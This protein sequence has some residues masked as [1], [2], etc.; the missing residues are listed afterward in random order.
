MN[1][2]RLLFYSQ[3]AVGSEGTSDSSPAVQGVL[4][5][6]KVVGRAVLCPPLIAN[7]RI[8]T[9]ENGV[10][11]FDR[12]LLNLSPRR[13]RSDAPCLHGLKFIWAIRPET[14]GYFQ[15]VP[16]GLKRSE[17]RILSK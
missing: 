16:S 15:K 12:K 4:P 2:R 9:I 8:Q 14:P 7:Q 1:A 17:T 10:F 3:Q 11:F 13:A 6:S 5:K